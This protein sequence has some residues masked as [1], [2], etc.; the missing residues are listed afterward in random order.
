DP[1]L[2]EAT[3]EVYRNE[4]AKGRMRSWVPKY[5]GMLVSRAKTA[6]RDDMLANNE[7][8]TMYEFSEKPV[9]CRCGTPVTV[10]IVED[11][12][13]LNYA[14]EGWKEKTRDCIARMDLVPPETRAQFEHTIGW[15][16]EWPCTRSIGMGT[17]APWDPK[18]I[19]ESLSDST[20]YM[21]YY[22]IAHILK[23]I[24]PAKLTDEVFDYIFHG[25]G[26]AGSIS[27]STGI[28]RQALE[29]MRREFE[30]WYP[31][32]YRMSANELIPNHL[33]FHIFHHALLFPKLCPRGIISFG[34]AVL[35]GEKMSSSKGNIIAIN[36]AVREYGADTVRLYLMS[37]TE[38]W[39][40]LDWRTSEVEAMRRNLERFYSLAEEILALP[41][42]GRP[43]F[44]QPERW[45]QSRLQRHVQAV[46]EAL[47]AFET[48]KAVQHA[49]F[50][51]MQDLRWYMKRAQQ[52]ETRAHMLKQ[53]FNV[54]LRLLAPFTPHIC[55][56]LWERAKSGG[57]ISVAPWPKMEEG[58]IDKGAELIESY[59]GR[60]LEDVGKILRVTKVKKPKRVCL[61]VA[62][63][64]KWQAYRIAMK[65][66]GGRKVDFGSLLREI[67]E[68]LG[69]RLRKSDLSKFLQQA[70]QEL[71]GVPSEEL[72][73]LETTEIDELQVLLDAAEF[74]REQLNVKEVC[75]FKADDD[76]RYDPQDRAR[77]AVPL[78]P[79]I[80]IE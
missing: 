52:L 63:D 66:A 74:I 29:R 31:L 22:T 26:S 58:L 79:A 37:V 76:A 46:T 50:F 34:I 57:F 55:E 61:Y 38:P 39:Q 80:F 8:A 11:Q 4:F 78:R 21:A 67:G 44:A 3:A 49:F 56:E 45:M 30:Y 54:W 36:E 40:D 35:E 14:D 16:H 10:K 71:R 43:S 27:R 12:W 69:L 53:V 64:W 15:L 47:E 41:E 65:R 60:V 28:D 77:L 25:E 18:W 32:D 7:A 13:F 1:R 75:V 17:P 24:D 70:V 5:A 6:V 51:L 72:E 20:I 62:Q 73:I 59:L 68:K 2:E 23:T 9:V 19:I 48:R 42:T 33:T